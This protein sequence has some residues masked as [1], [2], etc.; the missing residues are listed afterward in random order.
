[1]NLVS[2]NLAVIAVCARPFVTAAARLGYRVA[3]FDMFN[4]EDTRRY[5]S[6]SEQVVFSDGGFDAEDLWRKLSALDPDA[7]I[8]VTYGSGLETQPELLGKISRNFPLLG[9][10][11]EVVAYVK[12]PRRF[13]PLLGKLGITHPEVRP[14]MPA[15]CNGWLAKGMGGSGG[16]HIRRLA[17]VQPT[18]GC[19]YQREVEGVPVS[20]LFLAD[21]RNATMIGFNEQWVSPATGLPFRYG[22]AVG[23][24]SLLED[25]KECMANAASLV[26]ATAGLRGLN[27]M[28]FMLSGKELLALEINPRLSATFDLYNIADLFE[29]HL[30]ACR[31]ELAVLP[32]ISPESKAHLI[33]YAPGDITITEHMAWPEWTADLP[34]PG[35]VCKAGAPLCTILAEAADA[36]AA[37]ALVFARARQLGAQLRFF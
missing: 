19:Y 27:S 32:F 15:N 30:Q 24:A 36:E 29:R 18:E 2:P 16:T 5:S 31:G 7:L 25:V 33:F 37:K 21:G 13:F 34:R 20:V 9:N 4:D 3:V 11:P 10:P 35:V 12:D 28:D 1:M 26:T 6:C 17:V 23:N 22:G 14:D 8:G